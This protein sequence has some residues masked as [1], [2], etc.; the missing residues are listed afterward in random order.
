MLKGAESQTEYAAG[1]AFPAPLATKRGRSPTKVKQD[2][3]RLWRKLRLF[4]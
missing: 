3:E 1:V 2:A 4:P